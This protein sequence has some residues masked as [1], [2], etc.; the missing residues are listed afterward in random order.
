MSQRFANIVSTESQRLYRLCF[1]LTGNAQEAEDL[2]QDTFARAFTSFDRFENRSEVSTWLYRI[3]MNAWKNKLRAKK[4]K[5]IFGFFS[6]D[7]AV[8]DIDQHHV[9][10]PK[11]IE[12]PVGSHMERAESERVLQTVL[13]GLSQEFREIIVLRDLE[14]KSYDDLVELLGVPMGTVKSRLARA[15]ETMRSILVPILRAKGEV[16]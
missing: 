16:L 15:R 13:A 10:E 11:S 9:R 8:D 2:C 5:L 4:L 3:A 14:E 1:R 12:A 6:K 7:E